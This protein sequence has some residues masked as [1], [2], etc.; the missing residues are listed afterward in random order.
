MAEDR[1]MLIDLAK[2]PVAILSV[3]LA[4]VGA[5]FILDI[6]FG[7]VSE[8]TKDGVK[9]SQDAK[10]EIAALAAQ[11]NAASKAIEEL[12]AQLPAAPLSNVARS[13]IFEASQTV[14]NQT[15]ELTRVM[16][17][18]SGTDQAIRGYIWIGDYDP[19][20]SKWT[21]NKLIVPSTNTSP[22]AP[23]RTIAP[24]SEYA[25]SGNMVLRDGLPRN[26]T[27][28][29]QGRKS[30]GIVPTGSRVRILS[31]PEAVDR[32][33]AVQYWTQVEVLQ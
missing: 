20:E 6:P 21:R 29:Y 32:E 10:G 8:I 11:V 19:N 27:E 4:L 12:K 33:F 28:Y 26:D 15:A 31:Q 1:Q 14:S 23:P 24:G 30:L 25:V 5:K 13:E 3:F 16:P 2:Y 18:K 22:A 7:S 9:F 17:A